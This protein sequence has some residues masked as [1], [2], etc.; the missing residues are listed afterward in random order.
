MS[1][2]IELSIAKKKPG[3]KVDYLFEKTKNSNK[4]FFEKLLYGEE[5]NYK[6]KP[7]LQYELK[8]DTVFFL[9]YADEI[10]KYNLKKI[11]VKKLIFNNGDYIHSKKFILGT[12]KFGRDLLSRITG[13]HHFLCKNEIII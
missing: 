12:D 10:K 9:E 3:F 6:K 1:N 8:N 2:E 13:Y 7:I 4:N 5:L 11:P